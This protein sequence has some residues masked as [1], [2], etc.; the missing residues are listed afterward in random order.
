MKLIR[1]LYDAYNRWEDNGGRRLGAALAYYAIFSAAPLF[2]ITISI[3]EIILDPELVRRQVTEVLRTT[4]GVDGGRV[5]EALIRSRGGLTGNWL[6]ILGSLLLM[7]FTASRVFV[8]LQD[9]MNILWGHE[10]ETT[11]IVDRLRARIGAV[12]VVFSGSIFLFLSL[13][14]NVTL[15]LV[16]AVLDGVIP[17]GATFWSLVHTMADYLLIAFLLTFIYKKIP[18][19]GVPWMIAAKAALL[20]G[21]LFSVGK[22][23][24][25]K[26]FLHIGNQSPTGAAGALV[27]VL[28]WAYYSSQ[29]LYF[30]AAIAKELSLGERA[31]SEPDKPAGV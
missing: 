4:L 19:V 25:G 27:V 3:T 2:V 15:T 26:Y 5:V 10:R 31:V 11:R 7:G 21:V 24:T 20:T 17:L 13:L 18:S 1:F 30:G 6:A 14:A 29:V 9:G 16:N 28:A 12:I 22:L 23:V 8:E